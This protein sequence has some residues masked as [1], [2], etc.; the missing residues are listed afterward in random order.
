[1]L[2]LTPN[3]YARRAAL[4]VLGAHALDSV[5]SWTIALIFPN[6]SSNLAVLDHMAKQRAHRGR[7]SRRAQ[8]SK[9]TPYGNNRARR[10]GFKRR[11][12]GHV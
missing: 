4:H 6:H 3:K 8:G 5:E 1:M 2:K 12:S 11:Y 10:G 9:P 7:K